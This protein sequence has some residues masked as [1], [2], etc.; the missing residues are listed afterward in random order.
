[1]PLKSTPLEAEDRKAQMKNQMGKIRER[2]QHIK[3]KILVMS[4]KGGVGFW[5]PCR[6]SSKW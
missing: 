5:Q 2:L 3:N 1:M 6:L 4:G